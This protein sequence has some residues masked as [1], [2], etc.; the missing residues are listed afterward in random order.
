MI[1]NMNTDTVIDDDKGWT[2]IPIRRSKPPQPPQPQQQQQQRQTVLDYRDELLGDN[3]FAEL[4]DLRGDPQYDKLVDIELFSRFLSSKIYKQTTEWR[5]ECHIIANKYHAN[6]ELT[7]LYKTTID[8]IKLEKLKNINLFMNMI[9]RLFPMIN[10]SMVGK[11][12]SL[13]IANAVGIL[14]NCVNN[15]QHRLNPG[16][17]VEVHSNGIT[18]T[19]KGGPALFPEH[20]ST[21]AME[22]AKARHAKT[23]AYEKFNNFKKNV[24]LHIRELWL[25]YVCHAISIN[26]K[27]SVN[28]ERLTT[29]TTK[30]NGSVN[31]DDCMKQALVFMFEIITEMFNTHSPVSESKEH[32]AAMIVDNAKKQISDMIM[33]TNEMVDAFTARRKEHMLDHSSLDVFLNAHDLLLG[34]VVIGTTDNDVVEFGTR[35]LLSRESFNDNTMSNIQTFVNNIPIK[36]I[37]YACMAYS[38]QM[39]TADTAGVVDSTGTQSSINVLHHDVLLFLNNTIESDFYIGECMV[40]FMWSDISNIYNTLKNG[41]NALQSKKYTFCD[42]RVTK[43]TIRKELTRL[44][45]FDAY[46]GKVE[47]LN[48]NVA[49]VVKQRGGA[50]KNGTSRHIKKYTK[51]WKGCGG[52]IGLD[53]I[54]QIM[55]IVPNIISSIN[56]PTEYGKYI[57]TAVTGVL[58]ISL[59]IKGF[60]LKTIW[61]FISGL[62][63]F[64][65]IIYMTYT[66]YYGSNAM[67]SYH[68]QSFGVAVAGVKT[69]IDSPEMLSNF[70]NFTT[71]STNIF[72]NAFT[73]TEVDQMMPDNLK[74]LQTISLELAQRYTGVNTV[75]KT[76][77]KYISSGNP[78]QV[79]IAN[80]ANSVYQQVLK[81]LPKKMEERAKDAISVASAR[82]GVGF[83]ISPGGTHRAISGNRVGLEMIKKTQQQIAPYKQIN[84]MTDAFTANKDY[85]TGPPALRG[86]FFQFWR[87]SY[88]A[89]SPADKALTN[90]RTQGGEVINLMLLLLRVNTLSSSNHGGKFNN[91]DAF[92]T[93]FKNQI[94]MEEGL[95]QFASKRYFSLSNIARKLSNAIDLN[96]KFVIPFSNKDSI[97]EA[98]RNAVE[99]IKS[100]NTANTLYPTGDGVP[101][102]SGAILELIQEKISDLKINIDDSEQLL[103]VFKHPETITKYFETAKTKT[104][105]GIDG[106]DAA[107]KSLMYVTNSLAKQFFDKGLTAYYHMPVPVD[108]LTSH[109]T[110]T[111]ACSVG[112]HRA[113]SS[114]DTFNSFIGAV[115][116]SPILGQNV[117]SIIHTNLNGKIAT[118]FGDGVSSIAKGAKESGAGGI[119]GMAAAQAVESLSGIIPQIYTLFGAKDNFN[120]GNEILKELRTLLMDAKAL[121]EYTTEENSE[122]CKVYAITDL[123]H[124]LTS[125]KIEF[126]RFELSIKSMYPDSEQLIGGIKEIVN[127]IFD[128]AAQ[129]STDFK[130][131]STESVDSIYV[132]TT[133]V[134]FA[135]LGLSMLGLASKYSSIIV[136]GSSIT[137][138]KT[139]YGNVK[140]FT[141]AG[142]FT[143]AENKSAQHQAAPVDDDLLGLQLGGLGGGGIKGIKVSKTRYSKHNKGY[144]NKTIQKT[145]KTKKIKTKTLKSKYYQKKTYKR[146][147]NI[148]TTNR[149]MKQYTKKRKNRLD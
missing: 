3:P 130:K 73:E 124:E 29:I 86:N 92:K 148:Y 46:I 18:I 27:F 50:S 112:V 134:F 22:N 128:H 144:K 12:K 40:S 58:L 143:R 23:A 104:A 102:V 49:H 99:V 133:T 101:A 51:K 82:P 119:K 131:S 11:L 28:S 103:D 107:Y 39:P 48:D 34:D 71:K 2:T 136:S 85:L 137:R 74:D 88:L 13:W 84:E 106:L 142:L 41:L 70:N 26:P 98:V 33:T 21:P 60:K 100:K 45:I 6:S 53:Q 1:S 120:K 66:Y 123:I 35:M 32:G 14:I 127:K 72:L 113:R 139:L 55:N 80:K 7:R 91:V 67:T 87:D 83:D 116:S 75:A 63:T 146:R 10:K 61:R 17:G 15:V 95:F 149:H 68:S 126:S 25:V 4:A 141:F 81:V 69:I 79:A 114:L 94:D 122:L 109:Q 47:E 44:E 147:Y 76:Y 37:S 62:T 16:P 8:P 108:L 64:C 121:S 24:T 97:I 57:G 42:I 54:Q 78:G 52:M 115:I 96:E 65:I 132:N 129:I 110:D 140:G 117:A 111:K 90:H 19:T 20:K 36:A 135:T 145:K 30:L 93:E 5:N 118:L 105:E 9:E 38:I 56:I 77:Q 43:D 31:K 125:G 89:L 59:F 138:L